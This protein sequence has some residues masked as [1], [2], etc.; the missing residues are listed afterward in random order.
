M[1][2]LT[3]YLIHSG[4]LLY[5]L[6]QPGI[7]RKSVTGIEHLLL[8]VGEAQQT[9]GSLSAALQLRADLL[10]CNILQ[11]IVLCRNIQRRRLKSELQDIAVAHSLLNLTVQSRL[12]HIIHKKVSAEAKSDCHNHNSP[13]QNL[14]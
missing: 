8:F 4:V 6:S 3:D 11:Y 12:K 7:L 9:A 13:Q 1:F 10:H 2:S 14:V 5:L